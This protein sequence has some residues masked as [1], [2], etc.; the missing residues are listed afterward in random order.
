[1]YGSI[2][3]IVEISWLPMNKVKG[4]SNIVR[5][6]MIFLSTIIRAIQEKVIT[7]VRVY[8]SMILLNS[9]SSDV[10]GITISGTKRK[11]R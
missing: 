9:K 6:K 4:I 11:R 3:R 10:I 2:E 7:I 1:M 5:R 8:V